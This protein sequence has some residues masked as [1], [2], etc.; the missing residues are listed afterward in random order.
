[1]PL[2]AVLA[3]LLAWSATCAHALIIPARGQLPQNELLTR[4]CKNVPDG[5][6]VCYPYA[7]NRYILCGAGN[8][9]RV[10]KC[11]PGESL[12]RLP[13]CHLRM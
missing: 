11:Q 9:N 6:T 10:R 5:W 8:M 3:T 13:T 2:L 12:P 1:M 4:A 7:T